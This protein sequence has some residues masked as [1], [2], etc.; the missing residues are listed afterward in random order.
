MIKSRAEAAPEIIMLNES[1]F[2]APRRCAAQ[3]VECSSD[4]G[5]ANAELRFLRRGKHRHWPA[6]VLRHAIA[7]GEAVSYWY[8]AEPDNVL[9]AAARHWAER[10]ARMKA[11]AVR[12]ERARK[13]EKAEEGRDQKGRFAVAADVCP[14]ACLRRDAESGRF[15]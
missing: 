15:V 3:L 13:R 12:N 9:Y 5:S 1:L 6:L 2:L 10:A 11:A 8:T 7:P 4:E 14:Q